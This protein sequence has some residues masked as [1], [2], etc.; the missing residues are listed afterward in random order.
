MSSAGVSTEPEANDVADRPDSHYGSL[1]AKKDVASRLNDDNDDDDDTAL[2]FARKESTVLAV[3]QNYH[4]VLFASHTNTQ[5][6]YH[7]HW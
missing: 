6:H 1:S 7:Q 5:A 4:R 2:V 3:C